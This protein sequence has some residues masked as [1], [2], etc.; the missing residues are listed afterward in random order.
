MRLYAPATTVLAG[1]ASHC[2]MIYREARDQN[3]ARIPITA[4]VSAGSLPAARA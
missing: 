2:G 4:A 3:Q 1:S